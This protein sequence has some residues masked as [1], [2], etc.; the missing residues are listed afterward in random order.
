M[1][2]IKQDT[3]REYKTSNCIIKL[4]LKTYNLGA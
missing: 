3:K 1:K 4:K 2:V